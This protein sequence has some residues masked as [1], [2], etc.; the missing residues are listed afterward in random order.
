VTPRVYSRR[1]GA[2]PIPAGAVYVGRGTPWGNPFKA[3]VPT[4][5]EHTKVVARYRDAVLNGTASGAYVAAVRSQ[6]RGKD[7]VCWCQSPSDEDPLPCHATVL[8]EIA[9]EEA[10]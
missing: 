3:S 5:E 10:A 7:L 2:D 1:K 8:L 9:N 6:L 4:R